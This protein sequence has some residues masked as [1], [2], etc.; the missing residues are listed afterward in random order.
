[1]S[2]FPLPSSHPRPSWPWL[3]TVGVNPPR[4]S[5]S[6]PDIQRALEW[7]IPDG[8]SFV[9]LEQ[10]NPKN[11][12]NY[13]F[14]QSAIALQG[15]NQGNY[16]VGYGWSSTKGAQLWERHVS[17]LEEVLPYFQ[18]AWQCGPTDL[19]GF[20]DRSDWLPVNNQESEECL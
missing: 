19:T 17:T 6:W 1:M 20:T 8:D 10:R 9:I 4:G 18:R 12:K 2:I 14:I 7:I 3:L 13:W 5:M 15:P 16:I 11:P